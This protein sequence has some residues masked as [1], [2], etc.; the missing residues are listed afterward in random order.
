M[1][2]YETGLKLTEEDKQGIIEKHHIVFRSHGGADYNLNI[3]PLPLCFH[4]GPNGPHH[5]RET[6]LALKRK[7]EEQLWLA[8]PKKYYSL[9][10]VIRTLDPWNKKSEK[11]IE[12][13]IKRENKCHPKGYRREDIIRTLMGG[14]FYGE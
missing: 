4:K 3:I 2:L 13:M 10:A 6:D 1:E 14:K 9:N 12:A 5:N 11:K 7:M 8:F